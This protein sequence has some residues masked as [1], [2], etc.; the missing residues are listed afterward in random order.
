MGADLFKLTHLY[1]Q[2]REKQQEAIQQRDEEA[3]NK[4]QETIQKA[5]EDI[6]RFYE[7]YN[8]KKQKSIEENR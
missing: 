7:E 2:W 8:E 4:K 3:E 5:R 1:S 6:D